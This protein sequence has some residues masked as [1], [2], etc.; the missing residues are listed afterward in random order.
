MQTAESIGLGSTAYGAT[1]ISDP[2]VG[3]N[4]RDTLPAAPSP[5][6]AEVAELRTKA[7]ASR[8]KKREPSDFDKSNIQRLTATG[9]ITAASKAKGEKWSTGTIITG[10]SDA[11]GEIDNLIAEAKA[12][13]QEKQSARQRLLLADSS[14]THRIDATLS[15]INNTTTTARSAS[16][17][18]M[19]K[20]PLKIKTE[21]N[22]Y[23]EDSR[24]RM[25]SIDAGAIGLGT[26]NSMVATPLT[27]QSSNADSGYAD[28]GERQNHST[29]LGMGSES[30]RKQN[31]GIISMGNDIE[32]KREMNG[33]SASRDRG[34]LEEEKRRHSEKAS[35]AAKGY[36]RP[37]ENERPSDERY[38]KHYR[39]DK[40]HYT[41]TSKHQ[42]DDR[43]LE[44]AMLKDGKYTE[45]TRED[46]DY[47]KEVYDRAR[48]EDYHRKAIPLTNDKKYVNQYRREDA[49]TDYAPASPGGTRVYDV[50]DGRYRSERASYRRE[51][52]PVDAH[53]R[54][55]AY[56]MEPP[57]LPTERSHLA[58]EYPMPPYPTRYPREAAPPPP[59]IDAEYAHYQI[60]VSDWLE[61]TGFHDRVY[62]MEKLRS[63]RERRLEHEEAM[64]AYPTRPASVLSRED[65][66]LR[67]SSHA[68]YTMP[69]PPAVLHRDE[70]PREHASDMPPPA[71]ASGRYIEAPPA[72][73]DTG[74]E[75]HGYNSLK[76]RLSFEQDY[77]IEKA[78]R[79][80]SYEENARSS[81][82]YRVSPE[83]P[84]K[85]SLASTES[86][87]V[88][89]S[90]SLYADGRFTDMDVPS[91]E[92]KRPTTEREGRPLSPAPPQ[93]KYSDTQEGGQREGPARTLLREDD[94]K[95]AVR[96]KR[97]PYWERNGESPDYHNKP[98]ER[99][100][101]DYRGGYRGRGRGDFRGRRG[102]PSFERRGGG[103]RDRS[104]ER[105]IKR[106]GEWDDMMEIERPRS[107]M[108]FRGED[109]TYKKRGRED[110]IK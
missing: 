63:Y 95:D 36:R 17:A 71:R 106:E 16:F 49:K 25:Q 45:R 88:S 56:R 50:D 93:R 4:V 82:P 28:N 70:R 108:Q 52:P 23:S 91:Q 10:T 38:V 101:E 57:L 79:T 18:E 8:N 15:T 24:D 40:A 42:A 47:R 80:S 94:E 109:Q 53:A 32:R 61:L 7:L 74:R 102:S 66:L 78:A 21:P 59:V 41:T 105:F 1:S 48:E 39:E 5:V 29:K 86:R 72:Y 65:H 54:Q 67:T 9:M 2:V 12:G 85:L 60:D 96:A 13:V 92:Y 27:A 30:M 62:R 100:R 83:V 58:R 26:K 90:K 34:P 64:R 84:R 11:A 76:R 14:E 87:R 68:S 43:H 3:I 73:P 77:P 107:P 104:R 69:P 19:E 31:D 6:S 55:A 75:T 81:A 33:S 97:N 103:Y 35:P 44:R 20:P 22:Q 46:V 51:D 89:G 99:R 98:Y 37:Y 110:A